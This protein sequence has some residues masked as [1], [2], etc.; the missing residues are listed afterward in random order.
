MSTF[1]HIYNEKLK[2]IA[3]QENIDPKTLKKY[4]EDIDSRFQKIREL[5]KKISK[6]HISDTFDRISKNSSTSSMS[7][8][9]FKAYTHEHEDTFSRGI[10]S[11]EKHLIRLK[12]AKH[13]SS[14][15]KSA[16]TRM[17]QV[18]TSL[19]SDLKNERKKIE[20]DK[21]SISPETK[22]GY[23]VFIDSVIKELGQLINKMDKP[24][25]KSPTL[26]RIK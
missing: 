21:T 3:E 14:D 2:V 8:K 16:V 5:A 13:Y 4:V 15:A 23:K 22:K 6:S 25:F 19:N 11:I 24:Y 12:T 18:L 26:Y 7:L 20:S 17:L 9:Q 10:T 1:K